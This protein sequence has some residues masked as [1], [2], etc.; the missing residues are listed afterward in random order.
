MSTT[1]DTGIEWRMLLRIF[2]LAQTHCTGTL[3]NQIRKASTTNA[4]TAGQ[5]LLASLLSVT[6][7]FSSIAIHSGS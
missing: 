3:A 7:I 4:Q 1:M 2:R 6:I 5:K